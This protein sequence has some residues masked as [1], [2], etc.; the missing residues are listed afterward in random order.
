VKKY[1]ITEEQWREF[2]RRLNENHPVIYPVRR[3]DEYHFD[4][5]GKGSSP[6]TAFNRFRCVQPLKSLLFEARRSV[7]GYFR[8]EGEPKAGAREEQTVIVGAKACDLHA[9]RVLDYVFLKE[10]IQDPFYASRRD[11]TFI[12]ASDCTDFKDVCFCV[13]VGGKPFPEGECDI[14]YAPVDAGYVVEAVSVKGEAL[15]REHENLFGEATQEQLDTIRK[16]REALTKRLEE[17]QRSKGYLWGGRTLELLERT[18]ESPVWREEAQR[19]V[20]CGACNFVCPTCHCFLLSDEQWGDFTRIRSWDSCQ[21]KGFSR[22]G[23]GANPRPELYQRLRNRYEK[24]FD[25]CPN[26]MNVVGC[27]GCGRCVEACIGKIDMR[28]V[29]KKLSGCK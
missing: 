19:C 24:K 21:Y 29:L 25:F 12:I 20:E 18:Y 9:L 11:R 15:I 2:I 5:A 17:H 28:E 26:V 14:R 22:V 27:T 1:F 6:G 10:P 8:G 7:G 16:N 3:E 23:G 13:L 4:F